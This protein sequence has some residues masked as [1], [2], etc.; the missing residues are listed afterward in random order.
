MCVRVSTLEVT[1]PKT[2]KEALQILSENNCRILA[3][4]TDL[5][6]YLEKGNKVA[7]HFLDIWPLKKELGYIKQ[8]GNMLAIGPLTTYTQIIQSKLIWEHLPILGESAKTIG[9]VQIQNR[10]TVGGNIANASPAG[11]TLPIFIAVKKTTLI[12]ESVEG[13]REVLFSSFYRGYKEMDLSP[14]EMIREIQIPIPKNGS[15]QMFYKVGARQAQ[16]ISKVV[17]A[18]VAFVRGG[19][20]EDIRFGVGS[21]APTVVSLPKTISFILK[22]KLTTSR[23][24]EAS[25]LAMEEVNPIDDI[26]SSAHYRKEVTGNLVQRFLNGLQ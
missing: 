18:G 15:Q 4:G 16:A 8:K 13:Q 26:R 10:G 1:Q 7:N 23:I 24:E 19:Q 17:L 9:A 22:E 11:D 6:V 2:L 20:V 12:V 14:Q 3:G 25:L 21:V 5:M